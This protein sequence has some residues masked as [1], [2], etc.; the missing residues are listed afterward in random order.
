MP[1]VAVKIF[2][3]LLKLFIWE[4][5]CVY[6]VQTGEPCLLFFTGMFY[7][8]LRLIG[9]HPILFKAFFMDADLL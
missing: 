3:L 8:V 1:I 9:L 5:I 4:S 2:F 7:C 6:P